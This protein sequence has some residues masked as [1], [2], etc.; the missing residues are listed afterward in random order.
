MLQRDGGSRRLLGNLTCIFRTHANAP[1]HLKKSGMLG[2]ER[3]G[4]KAH[5]VIKLYIK[6]ESK[7]RGVD[8]CALLVLCV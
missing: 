1:V 6:R 4:R 2:K 8:M 5:S 7:R 3:R